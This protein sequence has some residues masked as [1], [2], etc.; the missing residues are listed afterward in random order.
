MRKLFFPTFIMKNIT[1]FVWLV[2][3]L[4]VDSIKTSTRTQW[5]AYRL[6]YKVSWNNICP[7]NMFY[8]DCDRIHFPLQIWNNYTKVSKVLQNDI[9]W[10]KCTKIPKSTNKYSKA[11]LSTIRYLKVSQKNYKDIYL[12]NK[13][14][15][16]ELCPVSGESFIAW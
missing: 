5:S 8:T 13:Q 4:S 15:K 10:L 7:C 6:S 12:K 14:E 3:I 1:Y 9:K 16:V 11:P 2:L